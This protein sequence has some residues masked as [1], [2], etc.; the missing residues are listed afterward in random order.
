MLVT[1]LRTEGRPLE[2]SLSRLGASA[3]DTT[4]R[5]ESYRSVP[6]CIT[7]PSFTYWELPE[8]FL[9]RM[10]MSFRPFSSAGT[11]R[12]SSA[13]ITGRQKVEKSKSLPVWS[14]MKVKF[15]FPRS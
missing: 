7:R 9:P 8:N 3:E 12:L 11:P 15:T 10:V 4:L 14:A 5:S 6:W 2:V 13:Q 1:R